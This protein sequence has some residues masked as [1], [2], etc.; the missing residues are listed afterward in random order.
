MIN[1]S[2]LSPTTEE[3]CNWQPN[4][5]STR[6]LILNARTA[7]GRFLQLVPLKGTSLA[8]E[9]LPLGLDNLSCS[10]RKEQVSLKSLSHWDS[11]ISLVPNARNKRRSSTSPIGT[12]PPR[13]RASPTGTRQSLMFH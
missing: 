3:T 8:Q 9:P 13:S 11:A 2:R 10:K 1:Y 4:N 12:R 7:L 5:K 6:G